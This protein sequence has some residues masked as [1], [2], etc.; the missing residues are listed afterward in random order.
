MYRT[1]VV[2]YD[3]TDES[4]DGLVLAGRLAELSGARLVLTFAYG[5]ESIAVGIGSASIGVNVRDEAEQVL[6]RGLKQLPEGVEAR[7]CALRQASPARALHELAEHL[8]ADLVVLGSARF[9]AIGR[10]VICSVAMRLLHGLPCPVAVAPKGYA[11]DRHSPSFRIAVAWDGTP[12]SELALEAAT[13]LARL[14]RSELHVWHVIDPALYAVPAYPGVLMP[15]EATM[16]EAADRLLAT[17]AERLPEDV[18]A[19]AKVLTGNPAEML[20]AEA[21]SVDM[22]VMG[23]RGYG[24]VRRVLLGGVSSRLMR[25]SPCPLLVVPRSATE[26]V[27][28]GDMEVTGRAAEE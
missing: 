27:L 17:A 5:G 21:G 22:L 13:E 11:T 24:P 10:V 18:K 15:S 12:E 3:G 26:P 23:S 9:G 25:H 1:I 4:E 20:A 6:K 8:D 16:T 2:G 14:A 7:T 19:V 28:R